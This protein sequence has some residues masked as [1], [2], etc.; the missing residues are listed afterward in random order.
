MIVSILQ[1]NLFKAL[2]RTSRVVPVK[3]QLPVLQ[4]VLLSTSGGSLKITAT[5]LE[6]T[7]IVLVGAKVEKEGGI[8]VSSRLLLEFVSSLPQSTVK[9]STN[10]GSLAVQCGNFRATIPGVAAEEFP[11]VS[12]AV[13]KSGPA[14]EKSEIIEALGRVVFSAATDEGRPLLTGVRIVQR[15]GETVFAATDGYRLSVKRI[16]LKTKEALDFLVPARALQEV[17]KACTEEKDT[18]NITLTKP[19][20]GQV[21]FDVGDTEI[22][23]RLIDGEYPNFEK[24]IPTKY[25]TR[26]LLEKNIL[27]KAVKSAAIFAR[28]NANIIRFHI[29]NQT[30]TISA[31]TPQV[32][33]DEVDVEA[34][35]DGEGGDIA[36]NSRFLLEF[37]ANYPEEDVLFEMTGALNPGVFRPTKDDS[38]LHVIMPVRVQSS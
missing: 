10:E 2:S 27:E 7:E 8:C 32:G 23:T 15:E 22:R 29:E 28:D 13:K 6:T 18:K 24:I 36:F 21:S 5:N 25:N 30:L 31:N 17:M 11:P 35:V 4:N 1:E 3:P 12:E 38:Y 16:T 34:K 33:E 37:L 20:D 26:V 14:M 19:S 9:I